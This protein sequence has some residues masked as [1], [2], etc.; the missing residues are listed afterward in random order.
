MRLIVVEKQKCRNFVEE[1]MEEHKNPYNL[2]I[3]KL[4]ARRIIDE[5]PS[6][7]KHI[8]NIEEFITQ[9]IWKLEQEKSKK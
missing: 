3:S 6:K 8:P 4:H 2:E 1:Y 7:F 5:N 9:S